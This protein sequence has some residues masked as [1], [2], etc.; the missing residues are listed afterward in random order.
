VSD[1]SSDAVV[2]AF[3]IVIVLVVAVVA[4]RS[5]NKLVGRLSRRE[6][7]LGRRRQMAN[8][9]V[10]ALAALMASEL[11]VPGV[12]DWWAEHPSTGAFVSGALLTVVVLLIVEAAVKRALDEAAEK[13]WRSAGQA[14]AGAVLDAVALAM[15]AQQHAIWAHSAFVHDPKA[16]TA[17]DMGDASRRFAASVSGPVL[18]AA[19]VLTATES[20][21]AMYDQ[22]LAA[23]RAAA[24]Y[25]AIVQAM[26]WVRLPH[27]PSA[28]P[29]GFGLDAAELWWDAVAGPWMMLREHMRAFAGLADRKIGVRVSGWDFE[30]WTETG[31][32]EFERWLNTE[33]KMREPGP[34]DFE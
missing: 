16:N 17:V 27:D 26:A 1:A 12:G 24:E 25:E 3:R 6:E 15:R 5:S 21:H 32:P 30:P 13:R 19:P 11:I 10:A 23:S 34:D 8:A 20:L 2:L 14:A 4:W 7:D 29:D 22:A 31:S 9:A 28:D 18:A 33:S